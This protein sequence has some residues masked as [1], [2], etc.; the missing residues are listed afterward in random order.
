MYV[1]HTDASREW[2]YRI[3]NE[4]ATIL[5]YKGESGEVIVPDTLGDYPVT[6]IGK[7]AF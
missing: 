5:A 3:D 4:Q 7:G 1:T 2:E 6:A